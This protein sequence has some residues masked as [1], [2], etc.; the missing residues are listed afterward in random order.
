MPTIRDT[1][2]ALNAL[3]AQ[4]LAPNSLQFN[5]H[6]FQRA[7]KAAQEAARD[8]ATRVQPG[9]L[10]FST[11]SGAVYSMGRYVTENTYDHVVIVMDE[12]T[13]LHVGMPS[14]RLM[15]LERLLLPQR[16]P[17]VL[18]VAMAEEELQ[19][20]LRCARHLV[21]CQYDVAR[22][23]QLMV[24][25]ALKRLTGSSPLPRLPLDVKSNA[26]ICSDAILVLLAGC[27]E[28]FREAL[29]KARQEAELDIFTIGSAS[30]TDFQR[31]RRIEPAVISRVPLPV[32][33]FTLAP[34]KRS[35]RAHVAEMVQ[36]AQSLQHGT[37]KWPLPPVP[38]ISSRV[39]EVAACIP[40]SSMDAKHK[41]QMLSYVLLFLATLG[42]GLTV[43]RVLLRA[44]EMLMLRYVAHHVM[45]CL[46]S[47]PAFASARL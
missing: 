17:V 42:R 8:A 34:H 39:R 16:Q 23:Y 38:G 13:V 37:F 45:L 41:V 21:G 5:A 20:F 15:P 28:A 30:L 9:D 31:L 18:R 47:S 4:V 36:F 35:W 7:S 44:I 10:I 24:R 43:K 1:P 14:V 22:A 11:T 3:L 33:N 19:R 12:R 46:Q 29:A 2:S 25:L 32:V 26:W 40:P 27:C 6:E